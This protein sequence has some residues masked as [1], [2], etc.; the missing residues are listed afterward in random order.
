VINVVSAAELSQAAESTVITLA[1][2]GD[3]L[4]FTEIVRRRQKQVR[5]FMYHLCKHRNEGDDLA[6]Q[7]FLKAW[8]S[9][10]QLRSSAAFDAW[11][12]KIMV[13]TW[14]EA[15]RRNK[16][17]YSAESAAAESAAY[18]ESP[19][20]KID[21]DAALAQLPPAMRLC[22]VLAYHDGMTHE[23][24]S[25]IAHLPLGTVKSNIA[26]G[27]ARMREILRDYRQAS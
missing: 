20:A 1:C 25:S 4:A 10:H 24:I 3:S 6:Q 12:K 8:R 7:V 15:T 22:V 26:R 11:L 17:S 19:G 14:L 2:A 21:L 5:N 13:T 23:E 27:A 18:T 16:I 9:I